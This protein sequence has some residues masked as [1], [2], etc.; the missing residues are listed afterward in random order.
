ML[1]QFSRTELAIGPEGIEVMK[2]STIAVLGVG[3]VGSIAVEALARGGIGRIIMIDKDVVDITNI[4][5][6]IPALLTTIGQ[7]KTDVMKERLKLI[8]PE[9]DAV[10]LKMFYTEETYEKL[11]EYDLDY[12]ID[13]SDTITYKIHLIKQC[14]ERK[15]PIISCMGA[16]NKMDPTK[17]RVADISETRMDPIA[18]VVRQKLRKAG[19]SKGVKVVY[20][21]EPPVKQREDVT[22]RIVPEHAPEIR[23]AQ[24]PPASNSFV[25][26]VAG[27]IMVSVV[28]ND[29]LA[30]HGIVVERHT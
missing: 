29:L 20:S 27:L 5:R 24:Q 3:G 16:A 4:N 21:E 14:L 25:P 23:K 2:N 15:I 18:R 6:Q 22:Q 17:F 8:N 26:P 12:V 28:V 10:S 9:C 7:P 19:I 11:F 13:A 30:K 1:H